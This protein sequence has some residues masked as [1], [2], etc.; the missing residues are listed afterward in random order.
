[1]PLLAAADVIRLRRL[2]VASVSQ[3][4]EQYTQQNNRLR[5]ICI[6]PISRLRFQKCHDST[7][8]DPRISVPCRKRERSLS[9]KG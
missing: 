4:G 6:L 8:R 1:M 9:R 7:A 5:F 3:H 2:S